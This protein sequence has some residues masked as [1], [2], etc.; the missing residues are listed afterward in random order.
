MFLDLDLRAS[1]SSCELNYDDWESFHQRKNYTVNMLQKKQAYVVHS[2]LEISFYILAELHICYLSHD[3]GKF[4]QSV[5]SVSLVFMNSNKVRW[6]RSTGCLLLSQIYIHYNLYIH[7]H[8]CFLCL[9][10]ISKTSTH[11]PQWELLPLNFLYTVKAKICS[12]PDMI[13]K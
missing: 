4:S 8:L 2:S 12:W 5:S 1:C 6:L 3:S 10:R 13:I 9:W 7:I 11:P